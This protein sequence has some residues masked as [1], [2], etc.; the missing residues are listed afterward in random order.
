M[1]KRKP[2]RYRATRRIAGQRWRAQ[3]A[4]AGDTDPVWVTHPS[5]MRPD[6]V[7]RA[8]GVCAGCPVLGEC[9]AWHR[10]D[11]WFEGLAAGVLWTAPRW[12]RH[13]TNNSQPLP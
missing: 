9:M 3:A 7:E 1:T 10:R 6:A 12:K 8:R 13:D 2:K 5:A 11:E 4:C